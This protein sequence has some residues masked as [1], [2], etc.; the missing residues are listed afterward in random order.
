[1]PHILIEYSSNLSKLDAQ[2]TLQ[3]VN[4]ALA[5]SGQF[6]DLDIKTRIA[7]VRD[8]L[9]GTGEQTHAF[10]HATL[11]LLNGRDLATRQ[12]LANAVL[13]ALKASLEPHAQLQAA[14][15]ISV[16]VVD[17]DRQAYAKLTIK[18]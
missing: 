11:R 5:A 15:Q 2:A 10:V 13:N 9:V 6:D 17:M 14:V 3:N 7:A 8:F 1:M 12:T 16:D 18:A 4:R